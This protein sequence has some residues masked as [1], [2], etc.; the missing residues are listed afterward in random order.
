MRTKGIDLVDYG[1]GINWRNVV[2]AGDIEWIERVATGVWLVDR[3][4]ESLLE[5]GIDAATG[6]A[7]A[8]LQRDGDGCRAVGVG[9]RRKSELAGW[10]DCRQHKEDAIVIGRDMEG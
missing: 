3:D 7:A 2:I 8:V 10:I 9:E 5:A 1:Q 6:R 4:D